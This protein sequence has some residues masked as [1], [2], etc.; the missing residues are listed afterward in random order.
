M[1]FSFATIRS[2]WY[3]VLRTVRLPRHPRQR[4]A[5]L[6]ASDRHTPVLLTRAAHAFRRAVVFNS[7]SSRTETSSPIA[8]ALPSHAR[9][10]IANPTARGRR[11]ARGTRVL[12]RWARRLGRRDAFGMELLSTFHSVPTPRLRA[13]C[14]SPSP[15][16]RAARASPPRGPFRTRRSRKTVFGG[17]GCTCLGGRRGQF[18]AP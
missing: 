18:F 3:A 12:F 14:R 8:R 17:D 2:A 5:Q 6:G 7:R 4:Q 13:S 11:V 15:S 16:R 10:S 1:S 9:I